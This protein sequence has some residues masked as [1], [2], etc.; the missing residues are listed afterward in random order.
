MRPLDPDKPVGMTCPKCGWGWATTYLDPLNDDDTIYDVSLTEGN[1]A[2][3]EII[4]A[5]AKI[6]NKSFVQ[7]K[8]MIE[9]SP[10]DVFSGKAAEVK[11]VLILLESLSLAYYVTPEFPYSLSHEVKDTDN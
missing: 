2:S 10:A 6:A 4:K 8:K 9:N 5:V 7:A 3:K 1:I 11:D